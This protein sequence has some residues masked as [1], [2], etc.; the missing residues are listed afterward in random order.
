MRVLIISANGFSKVLN[1]GKT[2]E[3]LFAEF[4][5]Q[6][7]SQIITRPQ[8]QIDFDF[9]SNY[10]C[11]SKLQVLK[12]IVYR[13]ASG[14]KLTVSSNTQESNSVDKAVLLKKY[15]PNYITDIA[16]CS[17]SWQTPVFK[18]WITLQNPDI[19]FLVGGGFFLHNIAKYVS[20]FLDIPI[21]TFFTDDYILNPSAGG[22]IGHFHRKKLIKNYKEIVKRSCLCFAIG[23]LMSKE[24]GQYFGKCFYPIMNSIPVKEYVEPVLK[25]DNKLLINYFGGLHLNRWKM[26]GRLSAL[27]PSNAELHVYSSGSLSDET[28][29]YFDKTGVIFEGGIYGEKLIE[30]MESSDILLHVESDDKINRRLTKLSVSTKIPEYLMAGRCI[31]GFG[32]QEVASMK[33]LSD[34][35]VGVCIDSELEDSK[36]KSFLESLMQDRGNIINV[37]KMGY[38]FAKNKYDG[39]KNAIA[40]RGKLQEKLIK[41]K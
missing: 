2:L 41:T 21:A 32:P 27:L 7:L 18:D 19:V 1:N 20:D 5:K 16:A 33:E 29:E 12:N 38:L 6:E 36:I 25:P 22:L 10:Y 40:F 30:A 8:L 31:I 13:K 26:I 35:K 37:G 24:Y 9:C 15:I 39:K 3:A 17:T 34:N 23:D 14:Y 11:I 4:D 28:R